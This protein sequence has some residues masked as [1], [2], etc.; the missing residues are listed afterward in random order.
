[1]KAPTHRQFIDWLRQNQDKQR[2]FLELHAFGETI[3]AYFEVH[4]GRISMADL[5]REFGYPGFGS[6]RFR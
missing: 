1:M 6:G 2:R 4:G 5:A 3:E